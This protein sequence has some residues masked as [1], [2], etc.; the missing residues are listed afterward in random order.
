[1]TSVRVVSML[2]FNNANNKLNQKGYFNPLIIP[3]VLAVVAT[4]VF[5]IMASSYYSKYV[6]Q[7]DTNQPKIDSA[8]EAAKTAQKAEL[9]KE[10]FEREKIPNVTYTSPPEFG[11]VKVTHAKTWSRYVVRRGDGEINFY[12]HPSY[13]MSDGVNHALRMSVVP[14]D[15]A[16]E[17]REYDALVKKG[18]LKARSVKAS[19]VNGTRLDGFFK[20]DLEGSMVV[21]PLRDKTLR[22]WTESKTFRGDFDNT[23]LKKLTFVP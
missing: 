17:M 12:A 23:V 16:S 13:V 18:D 2:T 10:F 22:V 20:K 15:F 11:S 1:M 21:F 5:G 6:D 7:R 9:E 19:G 8:V 3:L 14:N 4:V